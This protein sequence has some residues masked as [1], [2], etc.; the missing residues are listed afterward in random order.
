MKFL[1][2][3]DLHLGKRVHDFSML[4]DQ[5]HILG[6]IGNIIDNERIEGILIAGDIY[7][8]T[9]PSTEAV[10][11]FDRFLTEIAG[12]KIP[13]FLIGGN[14]DSVERLSFGAEIL[15][16]SRVYV[17][18]VYQGDIKPVTCKDA[19]GMIDIYLLPFI[20]PAYVR[21]VF[22]E[23]A[24]E[25]N[26]YQEALSLVME[27][28]KTDKGRRN[29]LVA[30]QFVTGAKRCDSEEISVGGLDNVD[31]SLFADF[32]YVALGHIHGPQ[33]VGKE[34]IRY[35]GTPLKYSFSEVSHQ[36]AAVVVELCEKGDVRIREIPLTP[37][38]DM[39][40][41]R[42]SYEELTS[43]SLYEKTN[44][45]D[46]VAITLTDETDIFDA[47][48]K[49]RVIYPNLMKLDYDNAR[50]KNIMEA[51]EMAAVEQKSPLTYAKELFA[52]QNQKEMSKKQEKYVSDMIREVWEMEL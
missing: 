28:I 15:A 30:H 41:I 40:K 13:V 5:K 47:L 26:S 25:I 44:T 49:L 11:L 38:H 7:D 31:A 33:W 29:I 43:R 2:L 17:A 27:R 14:H 42:G 3:A 52:M 16:D 45:N 50:V 19:Y 10:Q 8:K 12:K 35:A 48:G 20:K 24:Q 9:V 36:K 18:G 34:T 6:E 51:G 32:D 23:Q 4:E 37:L 22:P 46:Y 39:R 1:H 21:H